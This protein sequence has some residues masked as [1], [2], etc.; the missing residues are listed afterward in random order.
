MIK[1]VGL[2]MFLISMLGFQVSFTP[3]ANAPAMKELPEFIQEDLEPAKED[4]SNIKQTALTQEELFAKCL[5][6]SGAVFYGSIT[7]GHC[8]DQKELFGDAMKYIN[9]VECNPRAENARPQDCVSAN[10]EYFPTW[11]IGGEKIIGMQP[12]QNLAEKTTC[13]L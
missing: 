4:S 1:S 2:I 9:Y 10:I 8:G 13:E 12:L 3:V 5:T 11:I 6:D 7:C